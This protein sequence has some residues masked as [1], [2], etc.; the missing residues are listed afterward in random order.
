[1]YYKS[2]EHNF[3]NAGGTTEYGRFNSS[4]YL[5][6]GKSNTTFSNAGNELRGGNG[7]A[8]F[9]RS[10][11]EPVILNRTGSDGNI[12]GIYKD[13]SEVGNIG[14]NSA[15]GVPVLDISAHSSS[16]IMRMLTS[17]DERIRILATGNVGI[18][19][20]N[21]EGQ[22][23][24]RTQAS[25]TPPIKVTRG[26]DG[27]RIQ[28]QYAANTSGFG[29]IG[30]IY[31]GTGRTKIWIG[32]NLN[33]FSTAHN[34]ITQHDTGYAAWAFV[35]D[36]YSDEANI[37]RLTT[38]GAHKA[39]IVKPN[40]V[41]VNEVKVNSSIHHFEI[42]KAFTATGNSV[43]R[44]EINLINEIGATTAGSLRYE[45]MCQGY[46][47]GGANAVNAHYSSAGYSG[48]NYSST[49][50]GGFGAGTIQ[51]GYKSSNSTSYDAKGLSYHPCVNM[52]SY[53]ANGEIYAYVPGPQRYGFT[54]SNNHSTGISIVVTVRG[55]YK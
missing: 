23:H 55:F 38:A 8:R 33:S 39:L 14:S 40:G 51:N 29:E 25:A 13:G 43:T 34:S 27:G 5:L 49:N 54:I 2:T 26:L 24:V 4:G 3:Q 31:H 42:S 41:I 9:I 45:V 15:S 52:G 19:H 50:Y 36:S 53:I 30:Q 10:N 46:A 18:G 44:H 1:M 37:Q 6:V 7:G 48:H 32:A 16:G 28:L 11:A 22:L 35:S 17:G 20:T 21:P 12:F 47:S